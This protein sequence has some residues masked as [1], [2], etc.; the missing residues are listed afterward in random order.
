MGIFIKNPETERVV[1][2]LAAVRGVTLTDAIETAARKALE[3]ERLKAKPKRTLESMHAATE[4]FRRETGLDK[5]DL[6]I[7]KADVDALYDDRELDDAK[8]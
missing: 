7:T 5:V 3:E 4:R 6:D 1:R 2:E 8:S